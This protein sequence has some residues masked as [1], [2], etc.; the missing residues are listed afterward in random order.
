MKKVYK[1]VLLVIDLKKFEDIIMTSGFDGENDND[2]DFNWNE[3]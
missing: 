3:L 2:N 1:K